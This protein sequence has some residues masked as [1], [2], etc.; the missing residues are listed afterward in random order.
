MFTCLFYILM[1]SLFALLN[2]LPRKLWLDF[3]QILILSESVTWTHSVWKTHIY[4]FL[5]VIL[6]LSCYFA[7]DTIH[8]QILGCP[9]FLN[10]R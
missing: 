3:C 6:L 4:T 7:I 9:C 5:T 2:V 1:I 10:V 8:I